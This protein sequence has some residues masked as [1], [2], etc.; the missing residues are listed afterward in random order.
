MCG[1][2]E[3]SDKVR[4]AP[5]GA[6]HALYALG[7]QLT[8]SKSDITLDIIPQIA[9]LHCMSESGCFHAEGCAGSP[10]MAPSA[11][12]LLFLLTCCLSVVPGCCPRESEIIV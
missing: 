2:T 1:A 5:F 10:R 9:A 7:F 12:A 11:Q 8:L 3:A 6:S 4:T